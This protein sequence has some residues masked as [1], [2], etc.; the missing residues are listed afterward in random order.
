MLLQRDAKLEEKRY[1]IALEL[2]K[3]EE[4]QRIF[5]LER[6]KR[7]RFIRYRQLVHQS[8][9]CM[10]LSS[11]KDYSKISKYGYHLHY[12]V[13]IRDGFSNNIPVHMIADIDNLQVLPYRS[14]VR[15]NLDALG[16]MIK[17]IRDNAI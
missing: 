15:S 4:K 14:N 8:I 6:T 3:Q 10:D 2:L 11:L 9:R 12:I 13:S 5:E 16:A 1:K 7:K 17:D